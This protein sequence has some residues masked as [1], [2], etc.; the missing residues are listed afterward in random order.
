MLRFW[1]LARVDC[2]LIVR[3]GGHALFLGF[4][5]SWTSCFGKSEA[6]RA[7]IRFNICNSHKIEIPDIIFVMR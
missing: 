2:Y 7:N 5:G 1:A 6:I 4:W 3:F